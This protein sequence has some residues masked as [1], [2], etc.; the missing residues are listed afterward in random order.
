MNVQVNVHME[1]S[2]FNATDATLQ[3]VGCIAQ[4]RKI[5]LEDFV[6]LA[7]GGCSLPQTL[8]VS[9]SK[10]TF[11]NFS[12]AALLYSNQGLGTQHV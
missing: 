11:L 9:C 10:F 7:T 2:I 8:D 1:S 3:R 6:V 4:V 5:S 12:T